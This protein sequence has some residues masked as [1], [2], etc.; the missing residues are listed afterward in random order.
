M[1]EGPGLRDPGLSRPRQPGSQTHWSMGQGGS[2]HCSFQPTRCSL[3]ETVP[4][5][6]LTHCPQCAHPLTPKQKLL[7]CP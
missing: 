4:E 2:D 1:R 6:S 5:S 7:A 3:L